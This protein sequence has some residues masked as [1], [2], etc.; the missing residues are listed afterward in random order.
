VLQGIREE[1]EKVDKLTDY[2]YLTRCILHPAVSFVRSREWIT[3]TEEQIL[4]SVI[5]MK[6]VKSS[7]IARALPTLT[8]NQ[9]TYQ[10][11]NLV[12]QGMLLPVNPGARQYTIGFSNNYLVRGVI[13][14][15]REQG[16][17]PEPLDK[18]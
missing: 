3:E 13:K 10:I 9:R 14:A 4:V 1:L 18:P 12:E 8:P 15:L 7:D 16:F 17:I 2:A 11:K 5:K 6:V